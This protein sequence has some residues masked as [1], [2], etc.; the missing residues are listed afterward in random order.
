MEAAEVRQMDG[1]MLER[2]LKVWSVPREFTMSTL[3]TERK[4]TGDQLTE[5]GKCVCVFS[6]LVRSQNKH[7]PHSMHLQ[8]SNV[9]H[10]R[11][12]NTHQSPG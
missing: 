10:R 6:L 3:N 5:G 1:L 4:C 12:K 2:T 9:S 7:H 11:T 8:T